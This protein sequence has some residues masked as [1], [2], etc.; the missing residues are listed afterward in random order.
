MHSDNPAHSDGFAKAAVIKGLGMRHALAVV[1]GLS[2][3]GSA[4]A[5]NCGRVN[6]YWNTNMASLVENI[7]GCDS[8]AWQK[9][10]QAAAIHNDLISGSLGQRAAHCG[11][12]TPTVPGHDYTEAQ[13]ADTQSCSVARGEL[14]NIFETR[15]LARLACATARAGGDDQEWLDSQCKLYRSQ[16]SNYHLAFRSVAQH[17]E[18]D[19]EQQVAK[20][21]RK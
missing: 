12:S 14:R 19:Y 4:I 15:A 17:C 3:A 2:I 5:E 10:S 6:A 18:I 21:D 20:L 13:S 7:S 1:F 16:M 11:L 8:N 9:C